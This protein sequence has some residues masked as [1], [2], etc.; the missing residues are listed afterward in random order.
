MSSSKL[1]TCALVIILLLGGCK[2]QSSSSKQE[3]ATGS[4]ASAPVNQNPNEPTLTFSPRIVV[5]ADESG[6]RKPV[7]ELDAVDA[8]GETKTVSVPLEGLD[9]S[10][11]NLQFSFSASTPVADSPGAK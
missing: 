9:K 6:E 4:S 5:K 11:P 2:G 3:S 10:T 1:L 8:S 7:M